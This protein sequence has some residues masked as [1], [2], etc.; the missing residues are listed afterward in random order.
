MTPYQTPEQRQ[1]AQ[2]RERQELQRRWVE[3]RDS[4]I[5]EWSEQCPFCQRTIPPRVFNV[6][7]PMLS[8]PNTNQEVPNW[9]LPDDW[10][11]IPRGKVFLVRHHEDSRCGCDEERV[12]LV[13]QEQVQEFAKQEHRKVAWTKALQRAGL[14]GWMSKATFKSYNPKSESQKVALAECQK[15]AR[16][17]LTDKL[18]EKP[19]LVLHGP[20]GCG[21]SGLAAAI[22]REAL[23]HGYGRVI[24]DV[25]IDRRRKPPGEPIPSGCWFRPWQS[26]RQRLQNSFG[27]NAEERTADVVRELEYGR[28]V[29]IDDVDNDGERVT[30]FVTS[31]LGRILDTRSRLGLPTILTHNRH[32][33]KMVGWFG[34]SGVDRVIGCSHAILTLDGESHRSGLAW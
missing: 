7:A 9:V 19:W 8:I 4:L 23:G 34:S 16:L 18:D 29:V 2:N 3:D 25:R 6:D 20:N 22:L 5:A 10:D 12:S 13:E 28:L 21:K 33:L 15:Y 30:A 11:N 24:P 32:P 1:R 26:Y 31:E 14:V 17:M 27:D